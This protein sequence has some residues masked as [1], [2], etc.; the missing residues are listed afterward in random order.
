M[1]KIAIS[2]TPGTGKTSLAKALGF[3][4]RY[5]NELA[6]EHGLYSGYDLKR[7][8]VGVDL[9]KLKRVVQDI[10]IEEE[11][12]LIVEGHMAHLM[13]VDRIIV[14]RTDPQILEG[15]LEK[16][17][18]SREKIEENLEAEA[19]DV[20]LV[21]AVETGKGVS[22]IDTT[23]LPRSRVEEEAKDIILG[24]KPGTF[25]NVDWLHQFARRK[26]WY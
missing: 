19:L 8:T 18:Y 26:G 11:D 21:E 3:E 14:L 16:R 22:E 9:E 24:N 17:G 25:G 10:K 20:I 12:I 15:R 23:H 2:G 5:L 4:V 13:P 6:K 7:D 1:V